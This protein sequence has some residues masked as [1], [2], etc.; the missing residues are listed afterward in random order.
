MLDDFA[1]KEFELC[2]VFAEAGLGPT[3]LALQGPC[4]VPGG[5]LYCIRMEA[6][7]QTLHNLLCAKTWRGLRHGLAPPEE[8]E[9]H[10]MG[11]ALV[12]ALQRMF[13]HGLVHGDLH[14]H[15]IAV[16]LAAFFHLFSQA[17][18]RSEGSSK[19]VQLIDFGRSAS[20]AACGKA[21][22]EAFRAGHAAGLLMFT[23]MSYY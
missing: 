19:S 22:G 12:A 4:E 9:A 13:D 6:I 1:Q 3:P 11:S 21:C 20:K 23:F 15:N 10:R 18:F 14:L 16:P 8:A 17:L 7:Q 5:D 2:R